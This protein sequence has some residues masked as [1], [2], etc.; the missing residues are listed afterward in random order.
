MCP[1]FFIW[2]LKCINFFLLIIRFG[3]GPDLLYQSECVICTAAWKKHQK[4][5]QKTNNKTPEP[6]LSLTSNSS[7]SHLLF[8]SNKNSTEHHNS[9]RSN[10][11]SGSGSFLSSYESSSSSPSLTKQQQP[12]NSTKNQIPNHDDWR[13]VNL[14]FN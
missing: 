7:I 12:W 11:G 14:L 2:S 8:N 1:I 6:S 5:V 10:S 9:V 3:G 13:L 4:S